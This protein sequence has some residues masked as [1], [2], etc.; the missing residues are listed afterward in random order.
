MIVYCDTSA[1][2]KL[3]VNEKSSD[4]I[5]KACKAASHVAVSQIAWVEMCAALSLKQ[6]TGQIDAETSARALTELKDEWNR[7]QRLGIDQ[8]LIAQ[9]GNFAV[10]FGLRAY[11]SVQLATARF[12][13]QQLGNNMVMCCFDS[14]LNVAAGKLGIR[15]LPT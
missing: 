13:H 9:A 14:Q 3:F 11:D 12:A 1:L 2:M 15:V 4:T 6:R 8:E 7:Y 5:R 10:Q